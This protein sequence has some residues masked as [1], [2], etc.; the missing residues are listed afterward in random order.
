M[1]N[2]FLNKE[3]YSIYLHDIDGDILLA[4]SGEKDLAKKYN[5]NKIKNIISS[6][7]DKSKFDES[8]EY[9]GSIIDVIFYANYEFKIGSLTE[10]S[11]KDINISCL[12]K[13][14]S[15]KNKIR[16]FRIEENNDLI[17]FLDCGEVLIFKGI[18][19]YEDDEF[20]SFYKKRKPIICN[21]FSGIGKINKEIYSIDELDNIYEFKFN[22]YIKI[23]FR[24]DKFADE[25]YSLVIREKYIIDK[26]LQKT[27]YYKKYY[28]KAVGLYKLQIL[29][30]FKNLEEEK[31]NFLIYLDTIKV[32]KDIKDDY[33][34][35]D[36]GNRIYE[37]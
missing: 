37:Y 1:K 35:Y 5:L 34:F 30:Y 6:K 18:W 28:S 27:E 26:V 11:D 7:S 36:T 10:F 32:D 4:N 33:I 8:I 20:L 15:D 14:R 25:I 24:N 23:P 17:K 22:M 31:N 2:Q 12:I 13:V 3:V 9:I 29:K 16:F 19:I 21:R